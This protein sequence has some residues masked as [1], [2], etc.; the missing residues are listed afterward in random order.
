MSC[1]CIN[2]YI[3]KDIFL[4]SKFLVVNILIISKIIRLFKCVVFTSKVVTSRYMFL[5]QVLFSVW[6]ILL[7]F[8]NSGQHLCLLIFWEIIYH[9][10][11][12]FTQYQD[13]AVILGIVS[14]HLINCRRKSNLEFNVIY[15]LL[16]FIYVVKS[17][18]Q[19]K[20]TAKKK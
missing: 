16:T 17:S 18:K 4:N 2:F 5:V 14:L 15:N 7:L 1:N 10:N 6:M 19:H 12:K 20:N 9:F 11:N 13:T 8:P 3:L